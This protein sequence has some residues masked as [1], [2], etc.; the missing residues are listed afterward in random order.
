L[1][2]QFDLQQSELSAWQRLKRKQLADAAR[3]GVDDSAHKVRRVLAEVGWRA[4]TNFEAQ[5]G[6][7]GDGFGT[8]PS[9]CARQGGGPGAPVGE[10]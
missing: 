10:T 6:G 8:T 3:R 1:V 4:V 9:F 5:D 7:E 2:W